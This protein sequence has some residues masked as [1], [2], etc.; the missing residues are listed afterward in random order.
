MVCCAFVMVAF[1]G[2]NSS[3]LF[4]LRLSRNSVS[5]I[6]L[7]PRLVFGVRLEN[8][9]GGCRAMPRSMPFLDRGQLSHQPRGV[10]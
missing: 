4:R 6:S 3:L 10:T 1:F 7:Y 2:G 5:S 9:R 8:E